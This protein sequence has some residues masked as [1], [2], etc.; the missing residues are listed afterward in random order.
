M[1]EDYKVIVSTVCFKQDKVLIMRR[2][3][4]KELAPLLWDS[5]GGR[6]EKGESFEETAKR[7]VKE[8]TGYNIEIV[9][10]L[11]TFTVPVDMGIFRD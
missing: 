10:L 1:K 8:E 11:K 3:A 5:P 4:Q 7:E 9:D 2:N 6:I